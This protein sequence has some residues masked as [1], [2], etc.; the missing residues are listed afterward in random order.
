MPWFL[1]C[2]A[3]QVSPDGEVLQVL[4]DPTGERVATASAA[5]EVKGRLFLGSLMAGEAMMRT[6]LAGAS[7][8]RSNMRTQLSAHSQMR[9]R[10]ADQLAA[11]STQP[12]SVLY[13]T[14]CMC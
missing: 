14:A 11:P 6:C 10:V 9:G 13:A 5:T 3:V 7:T 1:L 2:G 8:E 12:S 4:L